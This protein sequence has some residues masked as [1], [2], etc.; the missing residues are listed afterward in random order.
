[1]AARILNLHNGS[2]SSIRAPCKALQWVHIFLKLSLTLQ[3]CNLISPIKVVFKDSAS[4]LAKIPIFRS[5]NSQF[6]ILGFSLFFG[7]LGPPGPSRDLGNALL[8]I[9]TS[10]YAERPHS[11]RLMVLFEP[12]WSPAVVTPKMVMGLFA[13]H[14]LLSFKK[15]N[16]PT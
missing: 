6:L 12:P 5:L 3:L 8:S 7:P 15:H 4:L 10:P 1:M 13:A 11:R 2:R 16:I 9:S 14:I